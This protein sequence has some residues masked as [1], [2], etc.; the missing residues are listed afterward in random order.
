[1]NELNPAAKAMTAIEALDQLS[2]EQPE[3]RKVID[4]FLAVSTPTQLTLLYELVTSCKTR[5]AALARLQQ[6]RPLD[7]ILG[8]TENFPPSE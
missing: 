2:K 8:A 1:M 5:D 7:E 4:G 6:P 3:L